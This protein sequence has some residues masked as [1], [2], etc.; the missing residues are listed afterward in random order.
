MC[1]EHSFESEFFD[2]Q[3]AVPYLTHYP[4]EYAKSNDLRLLI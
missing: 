3:V 2:Y 4:K 1:K